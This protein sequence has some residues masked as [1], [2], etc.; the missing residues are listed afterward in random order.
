M[1]RF[2]RIKI[3]GDTAWYHICARVAGWLDWYPLDDPEA[4]E[5]LEKLIR[6]YLN[7]FCCEAAAFCLMGNHYHLV[8][9]FRPFRILPRS[10]LLRRARLLYKNPESVL[11]SDRHWERFN[12]RIHDM[13]ELM[14]SLQA[15]Y[16][17]W[18]NSTHNRRGSFWGERF[19]SVLL[20]EGESVIDAILYVDLNPVRAGLVRKPEDWK[21]NSASRRIK[22]EANWMI[23]LD[24]LLPEDSAFNVESLYKTL[25]YHRGGIEEVKDSDSHRKMVFAMEGL[26]GFE[27][28]GAFSTRLGFFTNGLIIGSENQIRAWMGHRRIGQLYKRRKKPLAHQI[29]KAFFYSLGGAITK[30]ELPL[31][32]PG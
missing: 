22:N 26:R 23:P 32:A 19:K 10:E 8:L 24:Q 14:R 27:C 16:A 3:D 29:G 4:R 21:W 25:L 9:R 15:E 6:K 11:V 7:V 30:K 5:H 18:Y 17:K 20:G 2:S 1:A 28:P 12:S 31:V 13:S